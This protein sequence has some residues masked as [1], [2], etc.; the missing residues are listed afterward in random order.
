MLAL[1]LTAC[2]GLPQPGDPLRVQVAGIEPLPTEGLELRFAVKLRV[3]NPNDA[4]VDYHGVALDLSVN[5][6]ALAS[7][8][9]GLKGSIPGYG[10]SV[11][12]VPVT[13]SAFAAFRQA[14]GVTETSG[15]DKLP[16]VLNGKLAG[17]VFGTTRFSDQGTLR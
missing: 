1:A 5:G 17:G 14:L 8:V 7:G 4:A 13:I 3:Q 12:S 6:R 2:A 10:E 9:S 11:L 16:Y 15:L